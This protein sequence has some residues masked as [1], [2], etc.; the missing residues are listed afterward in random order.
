MWIIYSLQGFVFGRVG[1]IYSR[2]IVLFLLLVSLYYTFYALSRYKLPSYMKGLAVFVTVLSMYGFFLM[3]YS[4]TM[5]KTSGEAVSS[6]T[7]LQ[8][9][10][11]SLLPV[12]PV[13]VFTIKGK[14]NKTILQWWI[15]VFFIATTL[16][17]YH[18]QQQ[19]LLQSI[20]AG[21]QREEF[22]NNYGY[23]FLALLPLMAFFSKNKIIQYFGIAYAM[24][25]M[26]MAMKRGAIIIGF[27]CIICFMLISFKGAKRGKKIRVILLSI[28]VLAVTY[29]AFNKLL[30]NSDYF[31]HRLD[32]TFEGNSS[33]RESLFALYFNFFIGQSNPLT[34][35]FGHG[36]NSTVGLFG[37]Y[38]HNDWL[39]LA[40][41]Q[42]VLGVVVYVT[43]WICFYKSKRKARYDDEV[44]LAI[45][46]LF[47]SSFL[48]SFFSMSY[49]DMS[50]F[51]T[52]CIGYC[53][54][55]ISE[56]DRQ[57]NVLQQ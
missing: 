57:H 1:T 14:L 2:I 20:Q 22:T 42:G 36:A 23:E 48:R 11:C 53:M 3:L 49:G 7:Y 17:F 25:F 47:F 52:V 33:G 29:Y 45:S 5:I 40:I 39:E 35:L 56:N 26:L 21:S 32:A 31:N 16:L 30:V 18:H 41:N 19:Q 15:P 46:L 54:G 27:I 12:F 13:Y 50:I 28:G 55:M 43:Y 8:G 24:V 34:F 10:L 38:A 44:Y 4:S 37:Q 51:T 6:Y 9:V